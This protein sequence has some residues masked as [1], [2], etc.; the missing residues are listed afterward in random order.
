MTARPLAVTAMGVWDDRSLRWLRT[1]SEVCAAAMVADPGSAFASLIT[2][3]RRRLHYGAETRRC[4]ERVGNTL[5]TL[6]FVV[7][8]SSNLSFEISYRAK[9]KSRMSRSIKRT[10]LSPFVY[11]IVTTN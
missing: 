1:F 9:Y 6:V 3:T 7:E 4:F 8:L 11:T 2:M 5:P 10:V